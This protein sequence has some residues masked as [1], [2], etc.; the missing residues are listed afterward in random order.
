MNPKTSIPDKCR[1]VHH[2]VLESLVP[3]E[4]PSKA[5]IFFRDPAIMGFETEKIFTDACS[6]LVCA[7]VETITPEGVPNMPLVMTHMARDVEGGCELRSRFWLGY[8]I[9]AGKG[10]CLLPEG[11][12]IPLPL[13]ASLLR[14]NFFEYINLSDILANVYAEEKD[15][16][17]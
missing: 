14:H 16:W 8:Q 17:E 4:E 7:N 12:Q 2:I 10:K 11:L 6:F 15:N 3:G 9:L 1:E 5:E 13:V